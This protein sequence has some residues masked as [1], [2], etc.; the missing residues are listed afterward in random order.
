MRYQAR[1]RWTLPLQELGDASRSTPARCVR[2]LS[3]HVSN[4]GDVVASDYYWKL[5]QQQQ[6]VAEVVDV[7]DVDVYRDWQAVIALSEWTLDG[8]LISADDDELD[9]ET[10]KDSRHDGILL[11]VCV[12]GPTLVRNSKWN[13][14]RATVDRELL[15]KGM[16]GEGSSTWDLQVI[17]D[18]MLVQDKVFC[19][20]FAREVTDASDGKGTLLH[21][22]F[23]YKLFS[24]RQAL[25]HGHPQRRGGTLDLRTCG[26][27]TWRRLHRDRA[28]KSFDGWSVFGGVGTV[29]DNRARG[30]GDDPHITLN[31][32]VEWWPMWKPFA[33]TG[34]EPLPPARKDVNWIQREYG[35][36]IGKSLTIALKGPI[37]TDEATQQAVLLRSST[38][39][40][41]VPD[42]R[43]R[44]TLELLEELQAAYTNSAWRATC[45]HS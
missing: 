3:V 17:D 39:A 40:K 31:V 43:F 32:C 16:G 8:V 34:I 5:Y 38:A 21:Y 2:C 14:E 18:G 1:R 42:S 33:D 11:N 35:D 6:T 12:Q 45:S 36:Q 9:V 29:M 27:S 20:L 4:A 13:L 37:V 25:R 26:A 24:G 15:R 23:Y 7:K 30:H 41:K 19:G 22:A 28:N 10:H 44:Q